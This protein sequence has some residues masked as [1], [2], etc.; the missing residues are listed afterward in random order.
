M[1]TPNFTFKINAIDSDRCDI[2]EVDAGTKIKADIMQPYNDNS[3]LNF[4]TLNNKDIILAPADDLVG[5]GGRVRIPSLIVSNTSKTTENSQ[6]HGDTS[7][8]FNSTTKAAF[9][10]GTKLIQGGNVY[11]YGYCVSSS[12]NGNM[13]MRIQNT[14][15]TRT[16]VV[17]VGSANLANGNITVNN[18]TANDI[19]EDDPRYVDGYITFLSGG[20]FGFN[21]TISGCTAANS[22]N[23]V[24]FYFKMGMDLSFSISP[25]ELV[26]VYSSPYVVENA[27]H[28]LLQTY[29]PV[30]AYM[31]GGGG[32]S[33]VFLWL[34]TKGTGVLKS[35][36]S[37]SIDKNEKLA[38]S[39]TSGSA[40]R[41]SAQTGFG[42]YTIGAALED[43]SSN[44]FFGAYINLE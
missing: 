19:I 44:E 9:P 43:A 36:S 18:S 3:D 41:V 4:N 10:L 13:A 16:A 40:G 24:T 1:S 42:Q 33:N 30:G 14:A 32:T 21:L 34:Q 27:Q 11:R 6:Y 12:E 20:A 15:I 25:G 17:S 22:G 8:Y 28:S 23:D 39:L 31:N 38:I 7:I 26:S 2:D 29:V 35:S 37:L 5:N